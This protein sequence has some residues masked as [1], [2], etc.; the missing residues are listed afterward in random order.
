[1]MSFNTF[2]DA[3]FEKA[4]ALGCSAA[5]IYYT[6]G[7]AFE[8]SVIGGVTDN[9]AVSREKGLGLRVQFEGKNGYAYTEQLE[10]PATLVLR[11]VDNARSIEDTDEQPMQGASTYVELEKTEPKIAAMDAQ[12]RIALAIEIEKA[13]LA[14]DERVQRVMQTGVE[15]FKGLK[16]ICNTRGLDAEGNSIIAYSYTMP[17]ASDGISVQNGIGFALNDDAI[18]AEFVA[19]EGV[20]K[21]IGCLGASPVSSSN[22]NVI[23][24]NETMGMILGA[25]SSMF[26]ADSAQKGL[27]LLKDKLN[28]KVASD[29]VSIV[30]DPFHKIGPR[31]FDDEG[32]PSVATSVIENGVLK[33]FLHNL[34][35]ANKAGTVSTSN[36]GRAGA[37]SPVGVRPSNFILQSGTLTFDEL[38]Q[39]LNNGLVINSVAGLHSG[40]N[41]VSGDFSLLAS[42]FLVENGKIVRA[43]DQITIG[44][45]FTAFLNS[46]AEVGSDLK[47]GQPMGAMFGSPSVL[48]ENIAISG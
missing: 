20:K 23:I 24:E 33:S 36:A 47:F 29:K 32:V 21:A 5:E 37:A 34:K 28:E 12:E 48:I 35:T 25:F 1:M 15:S 40:L 3:A 6:E 16:R 43:V 14:A 4:L 41:P 42:G 38:L 17:I 9:F 22:Y 8:V 10:D 27:S 7:D 30:D 46:V 45:N 26:S 44:S 39:K 2:K 13:A 18:D 19:N 31:R 11:A